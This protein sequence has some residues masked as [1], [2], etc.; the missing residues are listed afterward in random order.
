MRQGQGVV[1][2]QRG[3]AQRRY[4]PDAAHDL[5]EGVKDMMAEAATLCA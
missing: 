2:T 3:E 5:F 1:F 4:F